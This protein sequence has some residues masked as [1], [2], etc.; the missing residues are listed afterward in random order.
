LITGQIE[1]DNYK[2]WNG[3][4]LFDYWSRNGM[5]KTRW[6]LNSSTP[7]ENRFGLQMIGLGARLPEHSISG[8]KKFVQKWNGSGMQ[9]LVF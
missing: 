2:F 3:S 8:H 4:M 5:V 7:F 9:C 6:H 1:P